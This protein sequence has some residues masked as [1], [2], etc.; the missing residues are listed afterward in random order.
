MAMMLAGSIAAAELP[1]ARLLS[2]F[3]PGAKQGSS[4]EVTLTGQDLDELTGLH[5]SNPLITARAGSA[6]NKFIVTVPAKTPVGVYDVSAIGRDGVSNPRAFMV[7]SE[8]EILGKPGNISMEKAAAIAVGETI[9]AVCEANAVGYY[10]LA[11][12]K[13]ERIFAQ[14]SAREIDSRMEASILLADSG[15]NDRVISRRGELV[16]FRAPADGDYY[17]KVYDFTYRGGAELFYRLS[18]SSGPH[19]DFIF[20]PAGLAGSKSR[21][22]I[23]G[24]N[25]PGGF[26]ASGRS[27]GGGALE[28]LAVDI[29]LPA[30]PQNAGAEFSYIPSPA[31]LLD[32]MEYRLTTP[33]G[34]SNPIRIGFAA[35]P[36]VLR[37]PAVGASSETKVQKVA[38]PCEVAGRFSPRSAP[39][40]FSF[41]APANSAFWIEVISNRLGNPTAPFL[42]VQRVGKDEKGG[43]KVT[44][45]QEVYE[46]PVNSGGREFATSSRDPAYRLETKEAGTYR[47]T[48][49]DLFTTPAEEGALVYRLSIRKEAP[50]FRLVAFAASPVLEKDSKDAPI[51]TPL[52][53]RGGVTPIEVAALRQD[54]FAGEIELKAEGLPSGVSCAPAMIPPSASSATLMLAAADDAPAG[55]AGLKIT[56]ISKVGGADIQRAARFG[57]VATSEYDKQN[58]AVEVSSRRARELFVSVLPESS[59]LVITVAKKEP[60]ETCVFNKISIPVKIARR[61]EIAGPI[62]LKLAG[63]PLLAPFKEVTIAPPADSA[64]IDLDLAQFKLPAGVYDLNIETLAKLKYRTGAEAAK[65][66]EAAAKEAEKA[67]TEAAAAAKAAAAKLAGIKADAPERKA[68]EKASAEAAQKAKEADAA[69]VAFAAKAKQLAAKAAPKDYEASFYSAPIRLTVAAAPIKIAPLATLTVAAGAKVELPVALTRLYGFADAV[70]LAIVAPDIKGLSGKVTLAKDQSKTNLSIQ[71]DAAT[72]AGEHVVKLEAKLKV[73]GQAIT[74]EQPL[75]IKVT[76]K[77]PPAKSA[78]T[79]TTTKSK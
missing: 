7:G 65:E 8:N 6:G 34:V 31:S 29:E 66:A 23:F 55:F 64:T 73:G 47:I 67:A 69:K 49:R 52:L 51:S 50:D 30:D 28:Q 37:D 15:G 48:L 38:V 76:G 32:G 12:K 10:R 5:F 22:T 19:I 20:P 74:V 44:D 16:D 13:G 9:N 27:S 33:Q 36:V 24:R 25:L 63:H 14:V 39:Q 17:L 70:D 56:G 79:Q 71:A 57:T 77:A 42:L 60:L 78:T 43:E 3:P 41:D 72:P 54:G 26:P 35:A 1:A 53:R 45:V 40:I 18:V 21:Y 61:G 68:A 46:S 58:K 4:V 62:A 2:I 75:T 59:P 11:L